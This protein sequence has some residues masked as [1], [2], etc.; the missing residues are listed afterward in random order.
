MYPREEAEVVKM[1]AKYRNLPVTKKD[2]VD[3]LKM[4][5]SLIYK[6]EKFVFND[7]VVKD[8]F[9]LQGTIPV[10]YKNNTYHIPI[11][12]WLMDTHPDNAPICYVKPTSQ[13]QIKVS[14]FVDHN[15]KIYLPY[16]HDWSP[17]NSDL[18]GLIEVM[19]VTFG[20]QPPVY[21]KPKEYSSGTTGNAFGMPQPP[22]TF[23]SIPPYP[24][25][26]SQ[27]TSSGQRY[28][29]M[30]YMTG[31]NT[32]SNMPYPSPFYFPP[33]PQAGYN[34]PYNPQKPNQTGTITEEH[35]KASLISAV[36]DKLRR[37][38]QERVNQCQ[39]EIDTLNRTKQELRE[40]RTK[41]ESIIKNL[42]KEEI[43][44]QKNISILKEK[45]E[46]LVKSLE[47]LDVE[48]KMDVDEAV[49]TT[50][51]LY[52]QLLNA[53]A[54]EASIE[55]AIYYL[56]E[57]F[58]TGVIDLEVFLKHV[59]SLSRKQFMLRA[60]MQKCRQKAGLAG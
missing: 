41:I 48:N 29:P 47:C 9:N 28:P 15:G 53:Y 40:G 4:Y 5:R 27:S 6:L 45:E 31:G 22:P 23:G 7:G 59:R 19:I 36:E 1:L 34:S 24:N 17:S 44:I 37:R 21:S 42:T 33:I 52:K 10:N 3:A 30:T 13:M 43:E 56:G 51:P 60:I 38:V 11:C 46:E 8:L 55:D 57:G 50:A 25:H 58:R 49:V 32:N 12:I 39:A 54:E 18:L 20:E 2:V 16:L 26:F 35:I 14:M